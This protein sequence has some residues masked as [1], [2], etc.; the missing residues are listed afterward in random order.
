MTRVLFYWSVAALR[1]VRRSAGRTA[2]VRSKGITALRGG[3]LGVPLRSI[4]GLFQ[5][6][7]PFC[8]LN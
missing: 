2:G 7:Q 6:G 1:R 3:N 5:F 4:M 8:H